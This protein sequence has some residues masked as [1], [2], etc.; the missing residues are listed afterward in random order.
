MEA[1][2]LL[3]PIVVLSFPRSGS[4]IFRLTLSRHPQIVIPPESSIIS[5][6]FP[7]YGGWR[8]EDNSTDSLHAFIQDLA[9]ARKFETWNIEYDSLI[10]YLKLK[11]P[12]DYRT[13]M[14]HVFCFYGLAHGRSNFRW[15]DKNNVHLEHVPLLRGLYPK[16][17][18]ILLTRDI[19]AI[20]ASMKNTS[21]IDPS[22]RYRPVFS[23]DPSEVSGRWVSLIRG[24]YSEL[25]TIGSSQFL[26]VCYED[27]V[28]APSDTFAR[29]F[30]FL[31]IK[32]GSVDDLL[33]LEK[34]FFSTEPP[35]TI[36]WK[37]ETQLPL[38]PSRLDSWR[39]ELTACEL[40]HIMSAEA[41]HL[42]DFLRGK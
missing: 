33:G 40:S 30:D 32:S 1:N 11:A 42:L 39:A 16:A 9:T 28:E 19:R 8:H 24:A 15:G 34:D 23:L 10:L 18:F 14:A 41:T 36:P 35:A 3:K 22:Y 2:F 12:P 29:V 17:H 31:R 20:Y 5:W 6:F 4:S 25:E 26:H 27:M 37:S 38:N 13:L 7:K 21:T